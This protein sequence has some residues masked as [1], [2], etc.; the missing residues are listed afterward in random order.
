MDNQT[1]LC[2]EVKGLSKRFGGQQV[3]R[4]VSFSL[5][6]GEILG[7]IGPNGAGK[8]TLFNI[9]SGWVTPSGG[10][11]VFFGEKTTD[12]TP[13]R[14]CRAGM[15]RTFQMPQIFPEMS[16]LENVMTGAWFGQPSPPAAAQARA[17]SREF[18]ELVALTASETTPARDLSLMQQRLLEL[19][20]ALA[21]RPKLLLLDEIA[22]GLSLK[23][24]KC[25]TNLILRLR[26][27]GLTLLLTDHLLNLIM[28]VSD[29]LLA[30]DQGEIIAAG[31]PQEIIH[32][33]E[34][35]SAYLGVR[36]PAGEEG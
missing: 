24:V 33:P 7:I 22:A 19:A 4:E 30:L 35:E 29:R 32:D 28:P 20:R 1:R 36:D 31:P 27:Q 18:L 2:L 25:L 3:L 12:W 5:Q 16:V 34:V 21:T 17:Q 13:D 10:E 26:T 6:E 15:A 11:V 9:I 14:L 23:A 8:T